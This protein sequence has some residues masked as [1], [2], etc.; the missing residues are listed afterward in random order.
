MRWKETLYT[1]QLRRPIDEPTRQAIANE[2]SRRRHEIPIATEL[3]W[4]PDQPQFTIRSHWV[5]FVV[6]F[7]PEIL[8]VDAQLSLTAKALATQEH[9]QRAVRIID[10]IA[11]DL[12]L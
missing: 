12:G 3:Q 4:H 10:A 6:R 7:T 1:R 5:S 11:T 2:Y 8:Q 9:R